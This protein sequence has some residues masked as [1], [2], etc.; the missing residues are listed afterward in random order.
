[1]IPIYRS[2]EELRQ[3]F[4]RRNFSLGMVPTMGALH[5]GHLSLIDQSV[6]QNEQTL[7]SIFV[8]P[9]QFGAGED[10]D[11]YPRRLEADAAL[12]AARGATAIFAPTPELMYG[13]NHQTTVVNFD[14]E[15]LYCGKYR[16]GHFRGV[17]TVVAKLLLLP[18][19][20]RAY[21][22]E[23]DRQQLF[24]IK[25]MAEDLD[26]PTQII[27]CPIIREES[28]LA[29][30]SRNEYMSE[31][32]KEQAP[33]LFELLQEFSQ[34]QPG[35]TASALRKM[36]QERLQKVPL[37]KELQYLEFADGQSFLPIEGELPAHFYILI[38]AYFGETRLIDNLE[39]KRP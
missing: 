30:S 31:E 24:L 16:P 36:A 25:R 26:L 20:D 29:M 2:K 11:Q 32:M 38:A 17:L 10:L 7:V 27:G 34:S 28:G 33:V 4:Q 13:E 5:E 3:A 14:L 8:N 9:L 21:F 35:T 22:G 1:M 6:A 18:L 19:P 12:C 39:V 37:A 23:K 15:N